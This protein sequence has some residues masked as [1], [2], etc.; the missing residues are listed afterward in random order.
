MSEEQNLEYFARDATSFL[1]NYGSYS[2]TLPHLRI[3]L[4]YKIK[5][6]GTL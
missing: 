4:T 3:C 6:D 5:S 1:H 2:E